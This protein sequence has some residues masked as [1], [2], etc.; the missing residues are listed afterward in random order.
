MF[1]ALFNL[2]NFLFLLSLTLH[3]S[4]FHCFDALN[5]VSVF[6][7]LP[8]PVFLDFSLAAQGTSLRPKF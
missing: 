3:V 6:L 2:L 1:M 7:S 5:L 4:A 8:L